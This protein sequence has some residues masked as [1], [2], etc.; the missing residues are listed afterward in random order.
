MEWTDT[1][2]Q[3]ITNGSKKMAS[4][5]QHAVCCNHQILVLATHITGSIYEQVAS[6]DG[7]IALKSFLYLKCFA[8]VIG[9][10]SVIIIIYNNNTN[11][12][13]CRFFRK[14]ERDG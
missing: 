7:E 11:I 5:L 8:Q 9:M 10:D 13:M 12:L 4:I 1:A 2:G 6:T 14:R 3:L